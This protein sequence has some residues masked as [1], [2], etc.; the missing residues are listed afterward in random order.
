MV[1]SFVGLEDDVDFVEDFAESAAFAGRVNAQPA[2]SAS[3]KK[4]LF[5]IAML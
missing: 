4:N 3:V 2:A 1:H 5:G